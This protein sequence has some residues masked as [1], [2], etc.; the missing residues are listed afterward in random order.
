MSRNID[1]GLNEM[2]LSVDTTG[3]FDRVALEVQRSLDYFD[4]HFRQAPISHLALVPPPKEVPGLLE[5]LDANLNLS[6]SMMN[7]GELLEGDVDSL[8]VSQTQCLMA[9]GAALRRE[10]KVL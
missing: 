10:E 6:A 2:E 1:I 8:L 9:V 5:Y 4:S 3:F 7:F